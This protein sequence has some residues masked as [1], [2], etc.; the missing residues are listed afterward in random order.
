MVS[1][2]LRQAHLLE[3]GPTKIPRDHESLFIIRHVDFS[4]MESSRAFRP[5]SS[6]V[7]WTWT[8]PPLDQWELLDCNGH[9]PSMLCVKWPLI[10]HISAIP[11]IV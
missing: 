8:T 6:Y 4:S 3:V 1:W 9:G 5:S 7:K 11:G 2:N 10:E